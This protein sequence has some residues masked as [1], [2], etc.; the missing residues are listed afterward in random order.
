MASQSALHKSVIQ[1][2]WNSNQSWW[3]PLKHRAQLDHSPLSHLKTNVMSQHHQQNQ[4]VLFSIGTHATG[5]SFNQFSV[6]E[7]HEFFKK[8]ELLLKTAS[9]YDNSWWHSWTNK[10]WRRWHIG[11]YS[12]TNRM[13][14]SV[15]NVILQIDFHATPI[16]WT[17]ALNVR[18]H[19]SWS[20]SFG[21]CIE[22]LTLYGICQALPFSP[23]HVP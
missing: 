17:L 2:A 20:Y 15:R 10:D 4:D 7:W 19:K 22:R 18:L 8:S 23:I 21:M 12:W 9:S 11:V 6:R 3:Q 1:Q 14:K 13:S 5:T 16:I